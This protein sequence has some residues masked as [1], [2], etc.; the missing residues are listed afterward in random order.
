MTKL[1]DGLFVQL[2]KLN[3]LAGGELTTVQWLWFQL[4]IIAVTAL[5]DIADSL[6]GMA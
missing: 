3:E 2:K 5:V 1:T 6:A 4:A